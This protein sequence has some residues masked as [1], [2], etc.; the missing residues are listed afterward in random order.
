VVKIELGGL[1]GVV[2]PVIGKQP[3]DTDVWILEGDAPAF[4]KSQGPQFQ[5][6]PIWRIELASPSWPDDKAK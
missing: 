4:L 3:P 5:D 1:A 2:A 6:G